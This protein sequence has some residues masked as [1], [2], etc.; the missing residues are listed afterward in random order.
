MNAYIQ[1]R[2][3]NQDLL[4]EEKEEE[5]EEDITLYN[6]NHSSLTVS[7]FDRITTRH[8]HNNSSGSDE[9]QPTTT[10]QKNSIK[11]N[12]IH[13]NSNITIPSQKEVETYLVE[14]R[15]QELLDRYG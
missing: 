15:K 9:D 14:R 2:D 11:M 1:E 12:L 7:N 4:K 6:R 8:Y 5:E 3:L 10:Y 13:S